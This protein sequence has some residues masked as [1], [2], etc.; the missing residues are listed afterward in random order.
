MNKSETT[1]V[2]RASRNQGSDYSHAG[3]LAKIAN[4]EIEL[5]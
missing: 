1:L 5:L 2:F 4:V 3:C